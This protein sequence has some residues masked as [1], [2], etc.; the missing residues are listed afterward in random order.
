MRTRNAH[1]PRWYPRHVV[2]WGSL[3]LA[4]VAIFTASMIGAMVANAPAPAQRGASQY[5]M[6]YDSQKDQR[7]RAAHATDEDCDG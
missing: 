4:A 7:C 3:W 5:G 2:L 6:D 1:K